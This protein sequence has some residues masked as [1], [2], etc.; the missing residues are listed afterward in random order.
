MVSSAEMKAFLA[1]THSIFLPHFAGLTILKVQVYNKFEPI[2]KQIRGVL[3]FYF[4]KYPIKEKNNLR[5]PVSIDSNSLI[6]I[7][8]LRL[9][10][11]DLKQVF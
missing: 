11:F 3:H 5:E 2:E 1:W 10:Y 4:A 6:K 9:R 7:Y 8:N